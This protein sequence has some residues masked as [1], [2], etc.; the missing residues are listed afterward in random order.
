MN[1][2]TKSILVLIFLSVLY[3]TGCSDSTTNPNNPSTRSLYTRLGGVNA[4][5]TVVAVFI[6]NV[7]MDNRI[8]FFFAAV[9]ADTTGVRYRLLRQNLVQQICMVTGGPCLYL[10]KDMRTA[11]QGMNITINHFNALVEDLVAALNSLGVPQQ[12]KNELLAILGPLCRDIVD[13]GNGT[14]CP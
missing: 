12:E 9:L 8:N 14:G 4:I 10:G 3:L 13:N 5:D 6:N 11:H 1:K 2:F 7:A